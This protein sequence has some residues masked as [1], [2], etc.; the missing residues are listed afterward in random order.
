[1]PDTTSAAPQYAWNGSPAGQRPLRF[2]IFLPPMH[3]VGQS[4]TLL[5]QP[6]PRADRAP[7]CASATTRRGSASTTRA[8]SR[9]SPRPR[10]SSPPPPSAP[11]HIKL[12]TGVNS[13]PY[14]HPLILADR[15][16]HARPPHP[17]PHDVRRRARPAD[18]RRVHARHRPRRAAAD[19]GGELRR[20]HGLFRGEVVTAETDWFTINE[21]RLQLRP[22]SNFD[23]AVAASISPSGPKAAGRHG[24]GLLSIAATNPARVRDAR[25]PLGGDGGAGRR[26]RPRPSTA[27]SGG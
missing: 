16:V 27:R 15:I 4:P 25:R 10:C 5:M 8:A 22:Y 20:H 18:L 13:L 26:S 21:G 23:I 17:G 11:R 1:M 24:V 3:P 14:H 19:D 12:G 6:R 7:R 2:G 9:R